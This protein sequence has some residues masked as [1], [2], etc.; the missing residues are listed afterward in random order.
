MQ[1]GLSISTVD[2]NIRHGLSAWKGADNDEKGKAQHE[3][4]KKGQWYNKGT[5]SNGE[6]KQ[7]TTTGGGSCVVYRSNVSLSQLSD[8]A[9]RTWI[10][11]SLLNDCD[12]D[13]LSSGD[14][15][16]DDDGDSDDD[17]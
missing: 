2:S 16:D 11:A 10:I 3:E 13:I 1:S 15:F 12:I 7:P 4:Q 17:Y 8:Y 6:E 14:Q 9:L 5:S